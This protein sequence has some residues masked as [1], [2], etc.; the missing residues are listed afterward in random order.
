[1]DKDT[2]YSALADQADR[3]SAQAP[4]EGI[5]EGWRTIAGGFRHLARLHAAAVQRW[6]RSAWDRE[7]EAHH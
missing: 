2:E 5:A 4:T 1:M 6:R 3:L 7:D